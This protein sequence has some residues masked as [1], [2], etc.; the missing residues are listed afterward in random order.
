MTNYKSA[1]KRINSIE[2]I[3]QADRLEKSLERLWSAGIFT[4]KEF[5]YLDSALMDKKDLITGVRK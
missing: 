2:T 3:E 4:R 5:C 1:I